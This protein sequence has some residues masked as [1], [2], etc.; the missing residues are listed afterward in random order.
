MDNFLRM[1]NAHEEQVG[2]GGAEEYKEAGPPG[3]ASRASIRPLWTGLGE[4]QLSE[5]TDARDNISDPVSWTFMQCE[6]DQDLVPLQVLPS[7]EN[8]RRV[9]STRPTDRRLIDAA[10]G[11]LTMFL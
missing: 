7:A 2:G 3:S 11:K 6:A 5:P 10:K 4:R 8:F 1:Q 9:T